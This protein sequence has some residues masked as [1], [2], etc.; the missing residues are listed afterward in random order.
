MIEAV[1][2]IEANGFN[3]TKIHCLS[4]N[5]GSIKST[6][7]Y[8]N[9][10]KFFTNP[11]V[12]LIGHNICRYDIPTVER[13]LG[14]KVKCRVVDTL[15]LSWYLYSER[16]K[17]GLEEWGE[18]FG[19]PKPK[20]V[21]WEGL[22][23]GEYV[24]RCEE[25]VKINTILWE[26]QKRD[27]M[28][29][30]KD[31]K[32]MWKL[33]DYLTFKLKC[34]ATQEQLRWKLDVEKCRSGLEELELEKG[35][36]LDLLQKAMPKVPVY[37]K[38]SKPKKPFLLSGKLS[39]TGEKWFKLLEEQGLPKDHCEDIK[40]INKYKE[41]NPGSTAQVKS[42]LY[43]LGWQPQTFK[44]KRDKET[45]EF[46]KIEQINV[47]GGGGICPSIKQLY[48]KEPR[49][50]LLDG[51]S[52]LTHRISI[53]RGF[54][55]NADEE[56]YI[57]AK[58][59]GFTN[60]LRF[61]HSVVVNLPSVKK[62]YGELIRGCLIAPEGYELVGSDMSSL[63]DRTKQ[64]Y[65]W[66]Y[67]PDYVTEMNVE[68]FDPHLDIG[69]LSGMITQ[70][71]SDAYKGGDKSCDAQRHAA[72]QVNYSCTYG[73][74]PAGLVRNTGMPLYEATKLHTTYWKRN[75]SIQ[76]IADNC[77]V[78]SVNGKKWLFNP[79]SELWYELRYEK[80]RFSTLNQGTG[81]WCFD[82]WVKYLRQKSVPICAQMHDEVCA[83]I[84]LGFR[85]RVGSIFKW[86][87]DQTN[88]E[89]GLNRELGISIDFGNSYAAVH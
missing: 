64:H 71:Q 7:D 80:D 68:G 73:V 45:N 27:L 46:T 34:A 48:D 61:K 84:K 21:D 38:M 74:T 28:A 32:A 24:H 89:L 76:A 81:V 43:S 79:V 77:V 33:I 2:D 35:L 18:Y 31:D 5:T 75:W 82:T 37:S 53:L 20:V 16:I 78:K 67:D 4:V 9:M 15:A 62:P 58:I 19:I 39:A 3:A 40:F 55:D 26:K 88:L 50:K 11:N 54:L 12:T 66:D 70:A 30:Y 13:I 1:F 51:L 87:I 41:P 69:V 59:A 47:E 57:Q 86:A 85:D 83:C 29:I 65:M 36:K 17:H 22:S 60:T 44:H 52:I 56:G 72:K 23:Y 42:W 63:E 49:L 8:A 10:R 25:D 14:I 6:G